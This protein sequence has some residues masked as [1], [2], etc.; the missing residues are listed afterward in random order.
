M[1][2]PFSGTNSGLNLFVVKN[3]RIAGIRDMHR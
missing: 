2:L 1:L 3:R